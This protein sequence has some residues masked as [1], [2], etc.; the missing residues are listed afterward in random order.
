MADVA[1]VEKI[2]EAIDVAIAA[3]DPNVL[4][5]EGLST[6]DFVR[7]QAWFAS[8]PRKPAMLAFT[9]GAARDAAFAFDGAQGRKESP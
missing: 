8:N 1:P 2:G 5:S 3:L 4:H 7:L 6:L 9:A